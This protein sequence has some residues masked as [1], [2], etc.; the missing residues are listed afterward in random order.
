VPAQTRDLKPW[1]FD[2]VFK[3]FFHQVEFVVKRDGGGHHCIYKGIKERFLGFRL[4]K[5]GKY[6]SCEMRSGF[7]SK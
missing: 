4:R 6:L 2:D 1:G 3:F 5:Q 7:R